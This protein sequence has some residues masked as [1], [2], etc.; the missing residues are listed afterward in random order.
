VNLDGV[1]PIDFNDFAIFADCWRQNSLDGDIDGDG[2]IDFNDLAILSEYWLLSCDGGI[3]VIF[4]EPAPGTEIK[5]E[6]YLLKATTPNCNIVRAEFLIND[7][8]WEDFTPYCD[9]NGTFELMCDCNTPGREFSCLADFTQNYLNPRDTYVCLKAELF[10]SD[11]NDANSGAAYTLVELDNMIPDTITDLEA[12]PYGTSGYEMQLQW[13]APGDNEVGTQAVESYI[14]KANTVPITDENF[15]SSPDVY[16]TCDDLIPGSK[17][18]AQ[19]CY[20]SDYNGVQMEVGG[21][22]TY[23]FAIKSVDDAGNVSA[24]SNITTGTTEQW[25]NVSVD[26]ISYSTENEPNHTNYWYDDVTVLGE[27]TNHWDIP[28]NAK[29]RFKVSTQTIETKIVHLEPL[30]KKTAYFNWSVND[31]IGSHNPTIQITSAFIENKN[32]DRSKSKNVKVYSIVN[33]ANLSF[34]SDLKWPIPKNLGNETGSTFVVWVDIENLA[35]LSPTNDL[36]NFT[37]NLDM[38]GATLNKSKQTQGTSPVTPDSFDNTVVTFYPLKGDDLATWYWYINSGPS[39]SEY[40]V[41]VYIGKDPNDRISISR[42]VHI[43]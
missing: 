29:V 33:D 21:F 39:D 5:S 36:Y 18:A 16:G 22:V 34:H 27:L 23:Y 8:Y 17:G 19:S 2:A 41:T 43:E 31:P 24:L 7:V 26:S 37:L 20:F 9:V 3:T 30:E 12:S 14:I 6:H 25:Y 32:G 13:T 42:T 1:N 15:D 40:D 35:G 28:A 38:D 4:E 11:A 10:D